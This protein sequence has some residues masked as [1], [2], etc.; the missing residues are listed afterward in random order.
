MDTVQ[1]F[2][3]YGL[4]LL[5]LGFGGAVMVATAIPLVNF[6]VIPAAVAGATVLWVE[7]LERAAPGAGAE[8]TPEH[9]GTGHGNC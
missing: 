6:L 4:V 9:G 2:L 7:R 5:A 1:G 3:L 8:T